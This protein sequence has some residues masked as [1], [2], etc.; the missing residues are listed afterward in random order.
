MCPSTH[1]LTRAEMEARR[2]S[3]ARRFT[4]RVRQ[5]AVARE[6]GVSRTT[7]NRWHKRFLAG[8]SLERRKPTGRPPRLTAEQ[9]SQLYAILHSRRWTQHSFA[10]EISARFGVAYH[11]DHVGRIMHSL[12]L[13]RLRRAGGAA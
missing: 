9:R 12:G 1:L 13:P 11:E 6:F 5:C 8:D 10:T 7:A 2:L 3:A 4:A